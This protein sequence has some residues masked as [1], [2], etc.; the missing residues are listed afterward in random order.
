MNVIYDIYIYI[1]IY[2]YIYI[3]IYI[4]I[5]DISIS[6]PPL[7]I[8]IYTVACREGVLERC[9]IPA[10]LLKYHVG[11]TQKI[12]GK[13]SQLSLCRSIEIQP[14]SSCRHFFLS[15]LSILRQ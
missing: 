3:Y 5:Y 10:P 1:Y 9:Y 12:V 2:V 8:Y 15:G 13:F 6:L 4:Y 11:S 7:S 14:K